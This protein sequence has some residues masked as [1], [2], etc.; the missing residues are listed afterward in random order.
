MVHSHPRACSPW[1]RRLVE[2]GSTL[3]PSFSRRSPVVTI[4]TWGAHWHPQVHANLELPWGGLPNS[5]G[6]T[7]RY[8][9]LTGGRRFSAAQLHLHS[10]VVRFAV[11]D[12][13]KTLWADSGRGRFSSLTVSKCIATVAVCPGVRGQAWL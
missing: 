8:G 3:V 2:D 11:D 7:C 4:S 12:A 13:G 9:T 6:I 10:A 5:T 1:P